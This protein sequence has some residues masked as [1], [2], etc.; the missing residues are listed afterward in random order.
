M[1]YQDE[2][3]AR[4]RAERQFGRGGSPMDGFGRAR[5]TATFARGS[6]DAR[7]KR[8]VQSRLSVAA[9]TF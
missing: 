8:G 2:I 1:A 3:E 7:V 5:P 4:I 6:G 9:Q